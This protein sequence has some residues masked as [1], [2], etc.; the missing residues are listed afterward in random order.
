M[1]ER[2]NEL[3]FSP[4]VQSMIASRPD[5]FITVLTGTNN[6]GKSA[7]LKKTI[8]DRRYLYIGVNRFYS[9]HHLPLYS[10]NKTELDQ[11]FGNQVNSEQ[12]QFQ[13]FEG[14]YFNCSSA[15]TRLSDVRRE[16]LFDKFID[17]FNADIRVCA[18]DSENVFSNRYVAVDGESLSV[19]SSGT[20]L[21]LGILAALMDERF[22]HIAIDEPELGLSP[23]LQRKLSDIIIRGEDRTKLLPH[24][25]KI[26]VSTHSHLFLDKDNPSNNYVVKKKT[27]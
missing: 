18:E 27:I 7:Y 6:S 10:E 15:I 23:I 2:F 16:V 26:I 25:P 4:T 13:N 17:L 19:T 5:S 8:T 9:F 14:S 12:Q 1:P 21:F 11:W 3:A 22:A 20:R 24:N